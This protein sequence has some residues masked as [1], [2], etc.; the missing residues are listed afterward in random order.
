LAYGTVGEAG[1]SIGARVYRALLGIS[2]GEIF[3]IN[4]FA[5]TGLLI[6]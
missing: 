6:K 5:A 2:P 3:F 4:L 1:I